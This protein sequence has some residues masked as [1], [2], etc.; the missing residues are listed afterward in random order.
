MNSLKLFYMPEATAT[1]AIHVYNCHYAC[2]Q[3]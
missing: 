1:Q 3:P 2:T